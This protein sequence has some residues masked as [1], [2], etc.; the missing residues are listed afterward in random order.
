MHPKVR[1]MV[2]DVQRSRVVVYER[3]RVL[4]LCIVGKRT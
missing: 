3:F 2:A 4:A 1:G